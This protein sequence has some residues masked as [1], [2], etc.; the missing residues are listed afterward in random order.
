MN[1]PRELSRTDGRTN[2][3]TVLDPVFL[4]KASEN[5]LEIYQQVMWN[6]E[7]RYGPVIEV[8]KV[9]GTREKRVVIGYKMGGTS[10]FFRYFN[11]VT[12]S[13]EIQTCFYP[14]ALSDLYHPHSLYPARKYVG[15]HSQLF[16]FSVM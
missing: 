9:E 8:F 12:F 3:G 4:E 7:K 13:R 5:T 10:H 2:I 11:I 14:S 6:A 16:A 1:P 15:T